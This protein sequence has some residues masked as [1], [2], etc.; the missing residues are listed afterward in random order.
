MYTRFLA[1]CDA[2]GFMVIDE[3]DLETHGMGYNF[4][5]W[6]WLYWAHLC[7]A[8]EWESACVDR[9]ARLY[10][11]DKN[12]PCVIFWSLGNESGCGEH[13]RAMARYIRDR[14][15]HALIHYENAHLEYAARVGR[16]F[17]DI[18]DVESRM[19]ASTEYLK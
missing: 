10:E 5:D 4:G 9:A 3:A 14:D 8:P 13:H 19:Y 6:D 15:A 2:M 12:H 11:R 16:D 17:S 18:S 7:D 1:L